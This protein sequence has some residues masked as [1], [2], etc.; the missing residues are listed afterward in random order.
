[1]CNQPKTLEHRQAIAKQFIKTHDYKLPMVLDTM[2]NEFMQTFA[3]WPIRF[4]VIQDGKL[5]FKAQPD[6]E[7]YAYNIEDLESWLEVHC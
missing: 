7:I 3:A 2:K 6:K 4:Y 5:V 1:V